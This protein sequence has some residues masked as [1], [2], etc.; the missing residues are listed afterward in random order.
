MDLFSFFKAYINQH[1]SDL[2]ILCLSLF[3]VT[4]QPDGVEL[5]QHR[6]RPAQSARDDRER[7]PREREYDKQIQDLQQRL[8]VSDGRIQEMQQHKQ[9][10]ERATREKDHVIEVREKQIQELNQQM[11][12]KEQ[13]ATQFQQNLMTMIHKL[14][15]DIRDLRHELREKDKVLQRLM[16]PLKDKLTLS[17]KRCHAAPSKMYRGFSTVC[18]SMAYFSS[19][20]SGQVHSYNSGAEEWSTLPECPRTDFTLTV[21][22]GLVTAVGGCQFLDYT[23]TLLSLMEEGGRRKWVEHF[24]HM[25]TKRGLAAVVCSGKALVVAGGEGEGFTVLTTV[26]VM[27]TDTLQWSTASSLPHPLSAA[28]A[29]VCRDSVYLVAGRH[30]RRTAESV[31]TCSLSDLQSYTGYQIWRPIADL[32]VEH[33]T[34]V[35][36]NGQLLAV[37]GQ[38]YRNK[39]NNVYSYNRETNSWEVI[40]HMPTPRYQCLVAVLPHNELMVVGGWTTSGDTD[41]IEIASAE[42]SNML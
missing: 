3:A 17:W 25:P 20:A 31:L 7:Q 1:C 26:E 13:V 22:N 42:V 14:Q 10:L 15:E 19:F 9:E 23:N 38:D 29:T 16:V 2:C 37:G 40:S 30:Q 12:A 11:A 35:T 33:S 32:P 6:G 8:Q 41:K 4:D 24:P 34:L 39:T 5:T 21:I 27:N 28:V 18:G 36:L